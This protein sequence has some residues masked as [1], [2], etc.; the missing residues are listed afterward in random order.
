MTKE[1]HLPLIPLRNMV[2]FPEVVFPFLVGRPKSLTALNAINKKDNLIFLSVQK[3]GEIEEPKS[4]DIEKVGVI[5]RVLKE[6]RDFDNTVKLLVQVVER[7]KISRFSKKEPF[8]KVKVS[9]LPF[10]RR[11]EKGIFATAKEIVSSF[12]N[13]LRLSEN[14]PIGEELLEK[15]HLQHNPVQISMNIA[16]QLKITFS[17]KQKLLETDNFFQMLQVLL[18]H[19]NNEYEIA[20]LQAKIRAKVKNNIDTAQK[21]MILSQELE[22]IKGELNKID[23]QKNEIEE[24]REKISNA[25]MSKEALEHATEE[26]D[27]LEYTPS[28]SPEY[29]VIL[30]YLD[31]LISIPWSK[32]AK[33]N[34]NIKKASIILE[35]SHWGLEKIKERI[36]EILAVRHL[37]KS[38]KGPV[39]CFVGPPG[40]GKT[41]LGK[42]IASAMGR[43]FVRISLGGIRDEAEIRGHRKTYIGSLPGK[44]IQ[45]MKRAKVINPV[46]LMDEIDKMASDF[47][48]DPASAMLEVLDPEQNFMFMDHYLEV[49]YDLSQVF[50]ITTA[51]NIYDIPDPLRD[52]MEIINLS[53][54]TSLE[55]YYIA[56]YFLIPRQLK[57]NGLKKAQVKFNKNGLMEIIEHFTMEAGVRNLERQIG[58]VCRKIA[59]SIVMKEKKKMKFPITIEKKKVHEFLGLQEYRT[60]H[61]KKKNQVGVVNGLAWTQFGGVYLSIE[62]LLVPGKG[63]ILITGQIGKVMQES[64]QIALSLI[65]SNHKK[66]GIKKEIFEKNDIHI[67]VPE[68]A[69]PKDGP[70]AGITIA[71]S[72]LSA[73]S[74]KKIHWDCA[75]TG[76]LTLKGDVLPIGGLKEKLLA[77]YKEGIKRVFIPIDNKNTLEEVPEEVKSKITI[78]FVTNIWDVWKKVFKI[79]E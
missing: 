34:E 52:R 27:K 76:E 30:N 48:G 13:L 25:Q 26:L 5:V 59:K 1:Y 72:L 67:H 44:I 65:K 19:V 36:I 60:S 10:S 64:A 78:D 28:Y 40:V 58:K 61:I 29:T 42:A 57:E 63:K 3:Q 12:E 66:L 33:E 9:T 14:S 51:N 37:A 75:M 22:A 38:K 43:T 8:Y 21:K 18:V 7:A 69:I 79:N 39:I 16:F 35:E 6:K 23:G 73:L 17:E 70:S 11:N 77:A 4:T 54:Y 31:W 24:L 20:K 2:A 32:K 15:I 74:K 56:K 68:G 45:T 49:S 47:R 46:F 71:T 50:F 53:G 62:T 55:K 41:S